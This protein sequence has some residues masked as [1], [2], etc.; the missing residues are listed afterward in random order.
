[1]HKTAK[2]HGL[3]R[4]PKCHKLQPAIQN[5]MRC[6][7]CHG[8]FYLRHPRSLQYTLAWTI[9]ALIMFVP[10]NLFPIMIYYEL[11]V[12]EPMT[13]LEGI[14]S[15]I[16]ADMFP[17]AF[18]VF[19]AS[20]FVPLAKL[21]GL[22]FLVLATYQKLTFSRVYSGKIYKIVEFLGPWSMLDVFVVALSGALVKFGIFTNVQP[23]PGATY[24]TLMVVFSMFAAHSFDPRLLWDKKNND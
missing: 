13:I 6:R 4:C 22:I 14:N 16:E 15:L 18:I 8:H 2:E 11:G 12:A 23:A 20:F 21:C 7:R 3:A 24:F 1:M 17:I 19:T 10:A 9:S 5:Y